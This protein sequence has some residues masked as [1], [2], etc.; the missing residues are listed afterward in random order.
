MHARLDLEDRTPRGDRHDLLAQQL[1]DSIVSNGALTLQD[2]LVQ[3][4]LRGEAVSPSLEP[5]VPERAFEGIAYVLDQ[6]PRKSRAR[7]SD[8]ELRPGSTQHLLGTERIE[9]C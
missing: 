4:G 9:K 2:N 1:V 8:K 6:A 5:H 7:H 3:V